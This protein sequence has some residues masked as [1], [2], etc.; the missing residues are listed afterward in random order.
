[1]IVSP[2]TH[3]YCQLTAL[4]IIQQFLFLL[5]VFLFVTRRITRRPPPT[6]F[7]STPRTPPPTGTTPPRPLAA[8]AN[9]DRREITTAAVGTIHQVAPHHATTRTNPT[10]RFYRATTTHNNKP[11]PH[12]PH[13]PTRHPQIRHRRGAAAT[14]ATQTVTSFRHR[15]NATSCRVA[16]PPAVT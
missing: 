16:S 10:G 6:R 15:R 4:E 8:D 13:Q 2:L 7:S 12:P 11:P 14:T 1:M 9:L 5:F 3:N